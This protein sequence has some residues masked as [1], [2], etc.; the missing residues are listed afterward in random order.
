MPWLRQSGL[1]MYVSAGSTSPNST[2]GTT[3]RP[4]AA[5]TRV[6]RSTHFLQ[7]VLRNH[8]S[9]AELVGERS[10]LSTLRVGTLR[11][12]AGSVQV[13]VSILRLGV[14][15]K[16]VDNYHAGGLTSGVDLHTG[17]LLPATSLAL[18]RRGWPN[19]FCVTA[20]PETGRRF[21][22]V[23][24]V[25]DFQR[26]SAL[27]IEAHGKLAPDLLRV[28]WDLAL[29]DDGPVFIE[30]AAASCGCEVF[31]DDTTRDTYLEALRDN[32]ARSCEARDSAHG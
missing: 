22:G 31:T 28:G 2:T 6:D 17:V 10:P 20:H 9:I 11:T 3:G 30:A 1:A 14:A 21:A 24:A 18:V 5:A 25:P 16:V 27:C 7:R 32:I 19:A 15:G 8:R 4:A 13:L 29:T 23:F 26:A 12:A